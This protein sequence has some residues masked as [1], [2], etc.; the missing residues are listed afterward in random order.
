MPEGFPRNLAAICLVAG[1]SVLAGATAALIGGLVGVS[2]LS[3]PAA[4]Q[5]VM[6]RALDL[7]TR[8][9]IGAIDQLRSKFLLQLAHRVA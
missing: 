1:R 9:D 8:G 4:A 5:D 6:N 7:A 2:V 3:A